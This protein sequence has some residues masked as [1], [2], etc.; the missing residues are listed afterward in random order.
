MSKKESLKA[1]TEVDGAKRPGASS[2]LNGG[3]PSSSGY[4]GGRRMPFPAGPLTIPAEL[5]QKRWGHYT[6][7]RGN[8]GM[9][10]NSKPFTQKFCIS[11]NQEH[12]GVMSIQW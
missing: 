4:R 8:K 2:S 11:R 1:I 12:G 5:Q 3:K 10:S 7:W 6:S 9:S